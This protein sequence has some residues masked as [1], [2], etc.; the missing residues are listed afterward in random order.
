[1]LHSKSDSISFCLAYEARE[2]VLFDAQA[3]S[4]KGLE[5]FYRVEDEQAKQIMKILDL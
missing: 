4:R 3:I 2:K 5:V 1:M